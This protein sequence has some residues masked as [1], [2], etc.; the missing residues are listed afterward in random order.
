MCDFGSEKPDKYVIFG[1]WKKG[2]YL[3]FLDGKK[4]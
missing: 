4:M 3:F 1:R 2:K